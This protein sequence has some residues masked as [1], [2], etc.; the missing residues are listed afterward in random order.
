M[1]KIYDVYTY[2]CCCSLDFVKGCEG[3]TLGMI[4]EILYVQFEEGSSFM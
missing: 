4:V 1:Y 2:F 3:S